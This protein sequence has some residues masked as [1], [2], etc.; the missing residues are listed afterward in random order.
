[1]PGMARTQ[2][3][4]TGRAQSSIPPPLDEP[5]HEAKLSAGAI[6]P[7]RSSDISIKGETLWSLGLFIIA[8]T[9]RLWKISYPSSVVFDEVHFLRFVKN[10]RDGEY[11]FDIHPPLGKLILTVISK[12]FCGYP[13]QHLRHNGMPFGDVIYLPLRV[14][15]ALFGAATTPVLFQICRT[16]GLSLPSSILPAIAHA[17]DNL[18]VIEAR[19]VVMD[20]QLTFFMAV[21]LL[22]ALK[23]FGSKHGTRKRKIYLYSTAIFAACAVSVKWTTA[24][25][26]LLIAVVAIIGAP[27]SKRS[28]HVSE[29]L[30]AGSVAITLYIAFFMVHFWLLPNSG[31]GDAF[32]PREFQQTLVNNSHYNSNAPGM[33]FFTSFV[34]LNAEMYRANA[35]IKT[36][37]HWES[38]WYQWIV[39]Q[40]GLLYFDEPKMELISRIY[41]IVNPF[42]SVIAFFSVLITIAILFLIYLPNRFL[43]RLETYSKLHGFAARATF[44]LTGYLLNLAP[45]LEVSRC[46]FLYHYI[47]PLFYAELLLANFIDLLPTRLR[48]RISSI[49]CL[50]IILA[51]AYWSPWIYGTPLTRNGHK[52]RRLWGQYWE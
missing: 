8:I 47:P 1:M 15:S 38:K 51:F 28:L 25:T 3:R 11:L 32:M 12:L 33:G 35:R 21:A 44:L 23:L 18:S 36:R 39:N 10:Y 16:L 49:C 9:V 31:E 2:R 19:V 52:L 24:V 42:V 27:F 34:Y 17:L 37:H 45:Y 50:G 30:G 14:T 20:A 46:T 26:P 4:R 5:A 48:N 13:K 22:T 43:N 29:M 6:L 40:R 7:Q 41:L